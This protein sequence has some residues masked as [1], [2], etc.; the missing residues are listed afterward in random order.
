MTTTEI[1]RANREKIDQWKAEGRLH[2]SPHEAAPILGCNAPYALNISARDGRM[3]T[4][5]YCFF[6][7]NLRI[8][9]AWLEKFVGG[10]A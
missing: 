5:S 6:G 7:R 8:M 2:V 3:P 4:G 1:Q 9:V 10:D